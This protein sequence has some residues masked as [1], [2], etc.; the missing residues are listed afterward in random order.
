M[1]F[2]KVTKPVVFS[3]GLVLG[4]LL[5]FA[6]AAI[7]I[8]YKIA[9]PIP[10]NAG[11][12]QHPAPKEEVLVLLTRKFENGHARTKLAVSKDFKTDASVICR[13]GEVEKVKF[14]IT[15]NGYTELKTEPSLDNPLKP[16]AFAQAWWYIRDI[17]MPFFRDSF[18][19]FLTDNEMVTNITISPPRHATTLE[20]LPRA[21]Q[22]LHVE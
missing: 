1:Y 17:C 21:N 12:A 5:G 9:S 14:T 15:E 7:I 22:P 16:S 19:K 11:P 10:I 8:K 13:H 2:L 3:H 6:I 4:V 20:T 18:N